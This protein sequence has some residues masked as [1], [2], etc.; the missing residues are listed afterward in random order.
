MHLGT[1][2]FFPDLRAYD[3]DLLLRI[4]QN[5]REKSV[6]ESFETFHDL[7]VVPSA[8]FFLQCQV[9]SAQS[10]D[11]G[12]LLPDACQLAKFPQAKHASQPQHP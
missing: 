2:H 5:T 10:L 6:G 11:V 1:L 8:D 4:A 12:V 7:K 3:I 9:S